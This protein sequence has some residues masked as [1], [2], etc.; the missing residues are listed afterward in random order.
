MYKYKC[1]SENIKCFACDFLKK[2]IE[3]PK[4]SKVIM[5]PPYS[6]IINKNFDWE[7]TEVLK[8]T[9]EYYAVFMEKVIKIMHIIS[10][11]IC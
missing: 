11:N 2:S 10:N 9:N 8:D 3:L 1:K 6:K 5:N 4:N 7:L